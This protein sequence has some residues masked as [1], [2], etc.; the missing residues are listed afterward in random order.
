VEEERDRPGGGAYVYALADEEAYLQTDDDEK[1]IEE[2]LPD[3]AWF[4]CWFCRKS[5]QQVQRLYGAEYPVRDPNTFA[6]ITL[7]FICNECV[8]KFAGWFAQESLGPSPEL[9]PRRAPSSS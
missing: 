7:I 2:P 4:K 9:P 3:P 6:I 1:V 5:S 8:A